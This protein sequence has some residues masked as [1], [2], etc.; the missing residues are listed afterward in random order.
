MKARILTTLILL[1]AFS[2]G[3][4]AQTTTINHLANFNSGVQ[5]MWGP[6][7]NPITLDQTITLFDES[8]NVSFNTGSSGIFTIAGQSF[9]GALSGSFSGR[10]GSEIRIEGFTSGTV[11]VDYPVNIELQYPQNS[12][13]DQGD[14]VSI[15]TDYTVRS[16]YDMETLYPSA[17][18]FF[19]DFYFEMGAF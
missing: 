17:G 2:H 4:K 14:D 11:E 1:C 13:Y 7:F 5:N 3:V 8:W 19:W 6:S 15:Q 10:I 12:T 9:G 18:E 16:G